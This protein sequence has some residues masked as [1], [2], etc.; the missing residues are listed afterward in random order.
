M[1]RTKQ[2]V[3]VPGRCAKDIRTSFSFGKFLSGHSLN[4]YLFPSMNLQNS[5]RSE[6]MALDDQEIM[7]RRWQNRLR[8]QDD[9]DALEPRT[10]F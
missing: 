4:E 7:L 10:F 1:A 8:R 9:R 5:N 2:S 3:A 6:S